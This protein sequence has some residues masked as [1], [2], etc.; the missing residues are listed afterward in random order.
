M[1]YCNYFI[2]VIFLCRH[3]VSSGI[4]ISYVTTSS[5]I[6]CPGRPC[7][8]LENYFQNQSAHFSHDLIMKFLPGD[9]QMSTR[10]E[11]TNLVWF[12]LLGTDA[13]ILCNT[14]GYFAFTNVLNVEILGLHSN[15]WNHSLSLQL[16]YQSTWITMTSCAITVCVQTFC[17]MNYSSL[18]QSVFMWMLKCVNQLLIPSS[19]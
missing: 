1:E 3:S 12:S 14:T 17:D 9:R 19:L 10:A 6:S 15:L 11:I 16:N 18:S 13:I 7:L 4:Q 8:T 2:I 5:D